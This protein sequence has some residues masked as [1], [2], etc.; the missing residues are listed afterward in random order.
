MFMA[1]AVLNL[2]AELSRIFRVEGILAGAKFP[3]QHTLFVNTHP[4]EV[5]E[6]EVLELSLHELRKLAPHRSIILEIHEATATQSTQMRRLREVLDELD[7]GLA[8]DDFGAGQARLVELA[9]VPPDFLKFDMMLLQG[10][11]T[12]SPDRQRMV[13]RLVQMTIDLEIAP[14]AEGIESEADHDFC[15]SIGF[16]HGQGFLYGRPVADPTATSGLVGNPS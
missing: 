16:T 8:Y 13:E 9:D 12:A 15:C 5:T 10:I 6:M 11:A 1:A 3:P 14:L 4:S 7:M 2:E